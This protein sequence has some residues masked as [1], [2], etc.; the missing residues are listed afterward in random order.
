[1]KII[2]SIL[3][4]SKLEASALKL[5]PQPFLVEDVVADCVELLLPLVRSED[6]AVFVLTVFLRLPK[7]WIYHTISRRRYLCGQ[8]ETILAFVKVAS[9]LQSYNLLIPAQSL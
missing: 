2:D 4:Y 3:D 6:I 1:L 5:E 7:N 9:L 8:L